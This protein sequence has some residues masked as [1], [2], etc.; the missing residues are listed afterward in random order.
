[1]IGERIKHLRSACQMTL[2]DLAK[3]LNISRSSVN[4]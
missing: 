4:A 3:K 1:M 2:A